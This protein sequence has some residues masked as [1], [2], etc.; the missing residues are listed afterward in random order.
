MRASPPGTSAARL[1]RLWPVEVATNPGASS[2]LRLL[3]FVTQLSAGVC[4]EPRELRRQQRRPVM[5]VCFQLSG[6]VGAPS[7]K[8]RGG[9]G[10]APW[11]ACSQLSGGVGAPSHESSDG[12]SGAP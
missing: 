3:T 8:S 4:A 6:G 2:L 10:G 1:A 9:S 12:S 7:H 5:C 11:C